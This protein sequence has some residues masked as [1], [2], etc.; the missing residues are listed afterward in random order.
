[1]RKQTKSEAELQ[2]GRWASSGGGGVPTVLREGQGPDGGGG[3]G[4]AGQGCQ[5][6]ACV[7]VGPCVTVTG[8]RRGL[9]CASSALPARAPWRRLCGV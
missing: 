4:G 2:A 8:G 7:V 6:R 9:L 5:A 1:M 3:A